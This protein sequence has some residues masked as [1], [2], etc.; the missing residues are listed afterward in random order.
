MITRAIT[1]WLV[2]ILP[3][4]SNA[5]ALPS[6]AT[7]RREPS[8]FPNR[9]RCGRS[10]V[11]S[12]S[13]ATGHPDH[14]P[15]D[16]IKAVESRL[17]NIEREAPNLLSRF[18]EPHLKSFSMRPGSVQEISVTSTCFALK[19]IFATGDC[20]IF[21]NAV[22][23][24]VRSQQLNE[25][26][27]FETTSKIPIRGVVKA[28]LRARWR[29]EDL[30]QAP[31]L[32]STVL[33]I[34]SDRSILNS[35]MDEELC[36]RVKTLIAATLQNRPKRRSGISQ[37]LS[38][39]ILYLITDSLVTLLESTPENDEMEGIGLGGLPD[40][41][42]PDGAA[43]TTL[44]AL[45]RC[46][47]VSYNELCRQ[48]AFRGAGDMT[49][50]DVKRL[51][52]SLLT[53]IKASNSMAGTAG[54]E[55]IQG[56][57]P[58]SGTK[59]EP[60]NRRLV[61]A[62]LAAFFSEQHS[63][64]T[65]DQGQPIFKSFRKTGRDVGNAYVFAA[66]T[67]GSLLGALPAEDFRPHLSEL[68]RMLTWI[69]EHQCV[70]IISD[71]CDP[72]TSQCYGKPLRGWASPHMAVQSSSPV[73]WST[74]QTLTC[75]MRMR[76]VVQRLQHMDVL[77]E[78]GGK[79]NTGLLRTDSWNRLLDTDLGDPTVEH[80]T[81]KDVLD[82][83]MIRPFSDT[84]PTTGSLCVPKVGG[85]YSAILFGPPGTA[86]TT[87]CEALAERMGWDFLVIDTANFLEDG[88]TNVAS[89]I[90]YVFDRLESLTNCVILFDEIEE[91]C[92]DRETPGLGMESRLLTTSMLTQLNDLRRAKK[93]IFFL[94]T[95]R[96]RAFDSA[97]IRPGRFDMQL[98]VGTPNL[99]SR[100]IQLRNQLAVVPVQQS[101]KEEAEESFR[102][103]LS[104]VWD[105]DAMFFNYLEGLQYAS[106]CAD[107]V[108]T[109]NPLTEDRMSAI[110]KAQAAVMTVRGQVRDEYKA[111]MGLYRL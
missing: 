88:L 41:A 7:K 25:L 83:R 19:T 16:E 10:I 17:E 73:A 9:S 44:L 102:S 15:F 4:A 51:A 76:K 12:G 5:F 53:Y 35:D 63:D 103:F 11:L 8:F 40:S 55:I 64:G 58:A 24:N 85:A 107:L 108:A 48:L 106:A 45:T 42:L 91:F 61:K 69:E 57:G 105:E 66:D 28:L 31:L 43:S 84:I 1:A 6:S 72:E 2:S 59:V 79:A 90:R 23:L 78:F 56:K 87:I 62:A 75:V 93:S 86:K 97:I 100:V 26:C 29:E 46:V 94:A 89:R 109:G 65:W 111:S 104:L 18:Y 67:V 21:S 32:L 54:R 60:P 37:S 68:D 101:V 22:D 27:D 71:Y 99:E 95:N 20:S 81:L 110:L 96:L 70:E 3:L 52:Y 30:F 92:L 50:F 47:E 98:F 80:R 33:Q 39:Y 38:D 49:S 82:E 74:A 34:D 77:E 36:H 14:Y 13:G